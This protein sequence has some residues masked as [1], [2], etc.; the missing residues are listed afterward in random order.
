M[1]VRRAAALLLMTAMIGCS[2]VPT[3]NASPTTRARPPLG[4]GGTSTT[5]APQLAACSADS[6]TLGNAL[7][8]AGGTGGEV[9]FGAHVESRQNCFLTRPVGVMILDA[10]G[11]IITFGIA[12][13][14]HS[15][16]S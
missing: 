7:L 14:F 15:E 13:T 2:G 8:A 16:V 5:T 9:A 4:P 10:T 3:K 1:V 6:L 12:G 11:R